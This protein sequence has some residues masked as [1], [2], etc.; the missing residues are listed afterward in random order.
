MHVVPCSDARVNHV[1]NVMGGIMRNK[2]F[3]LIVS[4]AALCVACSKGRHDVNII[5]M[6]P[7]HI[8]VFDICID[9]LNVVKLDTDPACLLYSIDNLEKA[10]DNYYIHSN[11]Y[12]R[13]FDRH[14][15][16]MYNV[17]NMGNGAKEL[18]SMTNFFISDNE[19]CV[20]DNIKGLFHYTL[21]GQYLKRSDFKESLLEKCVTRP[22]KLYPHGDGYVSVNTCLDGGDLKAPAL[23]IWNKKLDEFKTIKNLYKNTSFFFSDG[24]QTNNGKIIY[25]EPYSDTVYS[26]SN[27]VASVEYVFDMGGYALPKELHTPVEKVLYVNDQYKGKKFV[28]F[29]QYLQEYDGRLYFTCIYPISES[30]NAYCLCEYDRDADHVRIARFV[31]NNNLVIQ[32]FFKIIKG[33]VILEIRDTG[34]MADNPCVMDEKLNTIFKQ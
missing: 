16:F 18:M 34:K 33:K 28:G 13:V 25:W 4:L 23:S 12:L 6:A 20:F 29:P 11:K 3:I 15:R 2:S 32:S 26:V 24:L 31:S 14:G 22:Y 7:P 5:K 27:G 10:N 19:V 9:S 1:N 30:D 21:D 17:T 8:E